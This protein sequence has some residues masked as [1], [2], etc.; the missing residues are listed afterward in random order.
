M[1]GMSISACMST[2]GFISAWRDPRRSD[3]DADKFWEKAPTRFGTD[4]RTPMMLALAPIANAY[5]AMN[6]SVN[7]LMTLANIPS[8]RE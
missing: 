1:I 3:M 8:S 6:V 5:G 2:A 7:P 4:D